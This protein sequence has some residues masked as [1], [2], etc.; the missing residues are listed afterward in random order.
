MHL[1][2]RGLLVFRPTICN[3]CF[4]KI[5]LFSDMQQ[6][7]GTMLVCFAE[8]KNSFQTEKE[9]NTISLSDNPK[10]DYL[11]IC[12]QKSHTSLLSIHAKK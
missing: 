2:S 1:T 3:F 7:C 11:R 12:S 4:L 9:K 5:E 6:N 8:R 10:V